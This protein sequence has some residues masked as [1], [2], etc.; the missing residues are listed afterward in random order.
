MFVP[1]E[2]AHCRQPF[3]VPNHRR[4][5]AKYCGRACTD[6]AKR[7]PANVECSH[8]AKP[9]RVKASEL[10]RRRN[11]LGIHCSYKCSAES[12]KT[13]YTGVRNPN[14]KGRSLD[15]DGY[16]VYVPAASHILGSRRVK[17]HFAVCC[18]VLGVAALPKGLHIHHRDCDV[19]NNEPSNLVLLGISDHKWLHKQYGSATLW[20][21]YHGKI[22]VRQLVYWSDDKFRAERLLGVS[23]LTQAEVLR[24]SSQVEIKAYVETQ[25]LD[26]EL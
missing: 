2:C 4:A 17:L 14:Y 9:F 18:E 1:L 25:A 10:D 12:R 8:C 6:A 21:M 19:E 22:D 15:S 23:L 7:L 5:K 11:T 24:G 20:A 26:L 16:R 13:K 3:E